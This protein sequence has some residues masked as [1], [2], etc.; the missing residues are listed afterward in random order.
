M[1]PVANRFNANWVINTTM[2]NRRTIHRALFALL[3]A[4]ALSPLAYAQ[5][6]ASP[7]E[8]TLFQLTNQVRAAHGLPA[9]R[10]DSNLARAALAHAQRVVRE[11]GELEHQ[12]PG[13]ADLPTRGA[14]AAA[15]FTT[16]SENIARHAENPAQLQQIW[17]STAVHRSNILDP[18][19]TAIGIAVVADQGLLYAVED[20]SRN[21]PV[22]TFDSLEKSVA[23]IL[24]AHGIGPADSNDD[25]RKTC[26]MA[27]GSSGNPKLVIQWD[28]PDPTLLPD[29]LLRQI[30]TG[31]YTSAEVG[32]CASKR[33]QPQFTTYNV[34]VLL[35]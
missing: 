24:Q 33:P 26:T 7:A 12:Y 21:A 13:E 3:A 14:H 27:Q 18:N 2:Q 17:M 8:Q 4:M 32:V 11:P 10:W 5:A 29:V 15:H 31:R 19:L 35:Y 16:I 1:L 28:G 22:Q 20:F 6:G 25:A 9:L 30:A 23:Q 34:A